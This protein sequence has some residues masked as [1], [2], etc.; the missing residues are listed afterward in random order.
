MRRQVGVVRADAV[1][2]VAQD[3]CAVCA[4]H[5][6]CF[7]SRMCIVHANRSLS[8]LMCGGLA[9][10]YFIDVACEVREGSSLSR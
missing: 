7:P 5:M 3:V 1:P 10:A 9:L 6:R 4:G 8:K 2:M